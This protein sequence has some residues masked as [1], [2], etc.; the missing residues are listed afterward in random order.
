MEKAKDNNDARPIYRVG[1]IL[2]GTQHCGYR[3][4]HRFFVVESLVKKSNAPRVYE[5]KN[6]KND[7]NEVL[8]KITRYCV[9]LQTPCLSNCVY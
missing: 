1:D 6:T 5:I 2:V 7:K 9:R 4:Y 8:G 3:F